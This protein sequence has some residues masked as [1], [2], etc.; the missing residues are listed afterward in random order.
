MVKKRKKK[1]RQKTTRVPFAAYKSIIN[2]AKVPAEPRRFK[3]I[4]L[5]SHSVRQI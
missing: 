1:K 3:C 4:K 2:E 5:R